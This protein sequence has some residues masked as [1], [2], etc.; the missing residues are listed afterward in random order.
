DDHMRGADLLAVVPHDEVG[1]VCA[2]LLDTTAGPGTLG[3]P[4]P[5]RCRQLPGST[6]KVARDQRALASPDEREQPDP[7]PGRQLVELGRRAMRSAGKDLVHRRPKR[8][9]EFA[10]GAVVLEVVAPLEPVIAADRAHHLGPGPREG[11]P[12]AQ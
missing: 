3:E 1:A 8:S 5:E 7:A 10:E 12:V 4:V 11:D 6:D 9:E 2:D